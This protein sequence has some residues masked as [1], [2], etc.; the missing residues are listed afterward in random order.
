MTWR[1]DAIERLITY[2]SQEKEH[3]MLCRAMWE[4][5]HQEAERARRK[6]GADTLLC[7][8]WGRQGRTG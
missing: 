4:R 1:G 5:F 7:F 8:L 2:I 6:H 3:A